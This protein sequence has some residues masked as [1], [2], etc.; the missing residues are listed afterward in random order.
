MALEIPVVVSNLPP[1]KNIIKNGFN[2]ILAEAGNSS[3]FADAVINLIN[4][5]YSYQRI[6]K[7]ARLCIESELNWENESQKFINAINKLLV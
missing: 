2:A 4:D 3:S 1:L 7:N 5:N 6:S